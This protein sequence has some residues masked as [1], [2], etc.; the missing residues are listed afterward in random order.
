MRENLFVS[1]LILV[2]IVVGFSAHILSAK[3]NMLSAH[4]HRFPFWGITVA[5]NIDDSYPQQIKFYF[6]EY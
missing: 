4:D 5:L 2:W 1:L 3:P 6:V